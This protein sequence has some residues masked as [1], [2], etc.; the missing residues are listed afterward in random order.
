[1][2]QE[3]SFKNFRRFEN[4]PPMKLNDINILVG[5]NNAGKS[6][7]AKALILVIIAVR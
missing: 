2:I 4:F 7:V 6:T 1:M 5:P 3:I